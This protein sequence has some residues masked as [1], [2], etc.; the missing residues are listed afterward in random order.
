ME[1]WGLAHETIARAAT[2]NENGSSSAFAAELDSRFLKDL[3]GVLKLGRDPAKVGEIGADRV[4][5]GDDGNGDAVAIRPYSMA[6]APDSSLM[7]RANEVLIFGT[8][9]D[10][11]FHGPPPLLFAGRWNLTRKLTKSP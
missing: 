3:T 6:V 11:L 7:N 4:H 9:L 2:A 10:G 5:G 1:D 8:P